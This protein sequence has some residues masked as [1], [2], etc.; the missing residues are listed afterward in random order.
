MISPS[1]RD[2]TITYVTNVSHLT[3]RLRDS[4][5]SVYRIS[6]RYRLLNIGYRN[7]RLIWLLVQHYACV[8][9]VHGFTARLC[10]QVLKLEVMVH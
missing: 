4:V 9:Y 7:N 3:M 1:Y 8:S 2:I 5:I 6:Y 10:S